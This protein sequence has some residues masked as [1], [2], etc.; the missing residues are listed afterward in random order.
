MSVGRPGLAPFIVLG[1]L[2]APSLTET[3]AVSVVR[4]ENEHVLSTGAVP[5][6]ASL[7]PPFQCNPQ[8]QPHHQAALSRAGKRRW[9]RLP[10]I[11]RHLLSGMKDL[12]LFT[13]CQGHS[14]STDFLR[15]RS[16]G[17]WQFVPIQGTFLMKSWKLIP[18]RS[19]CST[20]TLGVVLRFAFQCCHSLISFQANYLRKIRELYWKNIKQGKG[21]D[22]SF[23]STPSDI[24]SLMGD[25]CWEKRGQNFSSAL[26]LINFTVGYRKLRY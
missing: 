26:Y 13:Q 24:Y 23:L 18:E 5:G 14:E 11:T 16:V 3:R 6:P 25:T 17:L 19:G 12:G 22:Y 1:V 9:D 4:E 21:L 20:A 7:L 15:V 2:E 8:R 10:L